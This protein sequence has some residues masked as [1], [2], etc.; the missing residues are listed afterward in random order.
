MIKEVGPQG[1]FFEHAH[2]LRYLREVVFPSAMLDR[3]TWTAV[4]SQEVRGIEE[5]ANQVAAELMRKE[6]VPP[7]SAEQERAIDEVV[8]EAGSKRRELGQV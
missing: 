7:L 6:T 3:S 5:K 2:T 8:A 1:T 4:M